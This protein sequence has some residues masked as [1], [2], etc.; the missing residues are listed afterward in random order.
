MCRGLGSL[1]YMLILAIR[2]SH[3][4]CKRNICWF[5]K[6]LHIMVHFTYPSTFTIIYFSQAWQ[7]ANFGK[8]EAFGVIPWEKLG[9]EGSLLFWFYPLP[10]H[11]H[12]KIFI[13]LRN[14]GGRIFILLIRGRG[15]IRPYI[16]RRR[17]K[18]CPFGLKN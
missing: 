10:T 3:I 16:S 11:T 12:R 6:D 17:F 1:V 9:G 7:C 5:T 2:S 15:N 18:L 13:I 8:D 14:R 4:Y